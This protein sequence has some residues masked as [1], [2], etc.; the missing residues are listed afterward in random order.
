M[1]NV[2]VKIKKL[3]ENLL[4]DTT[5]NDGARFD[6]LLGKN[7]APIIM[8]FIWRSRIN[9]EAASPVPLL[10]SLLFYCLKAKPRTIIKHNPYCLMFSATQ[11][12]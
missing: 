11:F 5:S 7:S 9:V 8:Y 12:T 10:H 1:K 4:L 6:K 3:M 2:R